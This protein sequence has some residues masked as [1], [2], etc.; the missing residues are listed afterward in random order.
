[1]RKALNAL[2]AFVLAA[3]A[4]YALCIAAYVG[5][6]AIADYNDREGATGMAVAFLIGPMVALICG[7]AGA[8][9]AVRR[10]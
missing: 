6:T 9:W 8:V 5:F 10:R 1:M 3:L 4:G 7:I 2:L